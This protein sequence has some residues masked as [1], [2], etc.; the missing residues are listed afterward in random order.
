MAK[1]NYRGYL[2][3]ERV[4]LKKYFYVLRP[5]LAIMWLEKFQKPA[6]IEFDTLRTLIPAGSALDNEIASLL[7]RKKQ[8]REKELIP[9]VPALNAFV[10][11]ELERLEAFQGSP[12]VDKVHLQ[13]LN[14]LL[15]AHVH[16]N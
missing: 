9:V 14:A 10:E 13:S 5:L 2:R 12:D 7:V 8:S 11:H 4:P 16:V 3:E 1:T 15:R 6:P